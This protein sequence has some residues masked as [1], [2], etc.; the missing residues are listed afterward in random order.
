MHEPLKHV[1]GMYLPDIVYTAW[2]RRGQV[3]GKIELTHYHFH[4]LSWRQIIARIFRVRVKLSESVPNA[5]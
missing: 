2:S 4:E 3:D 1:H 5:N